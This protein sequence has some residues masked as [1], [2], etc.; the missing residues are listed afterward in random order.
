[1]KIVSIEPTPSPHSMKVNVDESLPNGENQNFQDRDDLSNAPEYIKSLFKIEGVKG[2]YQVQDFITIQR[3]PRI[4][5]EDILP[6]VQNVLGSTKDIAET[7]TTAAT[8]ANDHFGEINVFIQMF[9]NIP[10]QVKLQD[11]EKEE[12]FGL[13][14]QFTNAA[15]EASEASDNMLMERKW[16]EQSPRY[17][18]MK[19]I[20]NDVI[21]ELTASYDKNRLAELVKLAFTTD[22]DTPAP[23]SGV[24]VTLEM[25]DNPNWKERYAAL[26]RM[27]PMIDDLDVLHKALDD[28]KASIRRLATAFLGMIEEPEVLPYLYK[29][30]KDKAVNV[31]RTAGDCLSDLGFKE[32]IPEMIASLADSNRLVRWRAAMYLY[33]VGDETA[34]PALQQAL[35]DQ[36]FE[37]RMQVKMALARIEGGKEAKGSIWHQM[38][39][40]TKQK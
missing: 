2:L 30:L 31:R 22:P 26:D 8:A 19:E 24:K 11:G 12:R 14:E 13:P 34:I 39:Q 25:L 37:V 20:G 27:D 9:R 40:A 29:A 36:E 15:M 21:E 17:G 28:E 6:V 7:F 3:N 16:I 32:A 18:D 4:R 5:W 1:M 23:C 38:T 10:M 33:E 35:N